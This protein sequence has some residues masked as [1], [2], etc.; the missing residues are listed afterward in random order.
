MNSKRKFLKLF[1]AAPV[2]ATLPRGADMPKGGTALP[3][4]AIFKEWPEAAVV[5]EASKS[6][7]SSVESRIK[8]L[9]SDSKGRIN[10]LTRTRA[11]KI[12]STQNHSDSYDHACELHYESLKSL[13]PCAKAFFKQR[14]YIKSQIEFEQERVAYLESVLSAPEKFELFLKRYLET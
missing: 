9:L 1:A 2:A 11:D 7:E 6:I 8:S 4:S 12:Q 10:W 13:S 5:E 3:A 14:A